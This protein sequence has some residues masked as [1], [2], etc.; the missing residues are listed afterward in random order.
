MVGRLERR[1]RVFYL[2]VRKWSP[3]SV[4]QVESLINDVSQTPKPLPV[5]YL[6]IPEDTS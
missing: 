5:V 3:G 2:H 6:T 4:E 1:D